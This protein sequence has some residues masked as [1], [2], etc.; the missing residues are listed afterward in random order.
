MVEL[1]EPGYVCHRRLLFEQPNF[2]RYGY[3]YGILQPGISLG[4]FWY[5]TLSLP[6]HAFSRPCRNYDCSSGKCLPGDPVPLYLYKE[7]FSLTGLV[8]QTGVVLGGFFA[9]P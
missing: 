5:D 7:P 4:I 8:A 1:V 6:Y 9:F 2:E 3:D